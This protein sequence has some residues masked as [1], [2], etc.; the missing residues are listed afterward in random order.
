M[1]DHECVT[2]L[3]TLRWAQEE[4]PEF[5]SSMVNHLSMMTHPFY[6]VYIALLLASFQSL[7]LNKYRP[8]RIIAYNL[9]AQL[10]I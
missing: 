7:T 2:D 3:M 8:A 4:G 6:F 9:L 5:S 10:S 1:I